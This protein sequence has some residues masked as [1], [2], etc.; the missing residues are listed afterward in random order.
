MQSFFDSLIVYKGSKCS[1][2]KVSRET[3][4]PKQISEPGN[5]IEGH[6]Y[7]DDPRAR[8]FFGCKIGYNPFEPFAYMAYN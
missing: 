6:G 8:I 7:A 3:Y 1:P 2:L 4:F 5:T